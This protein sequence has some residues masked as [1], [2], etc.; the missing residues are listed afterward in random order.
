MK[1]LNVVG[2]E[3]L[4]KA[5]CKK[6]APPLVTLLGAEPE[7]Q[8]VALRNI[9]LVIQKRPGILTNE[10]KVFFCKYNDPLYVKME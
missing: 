5:W 1:M 9:S 2:S 10:A 3:D 6:M 7:V 8:Y 4:S